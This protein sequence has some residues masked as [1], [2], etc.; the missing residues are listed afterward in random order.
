VD[1]HLIARH[2]AHDFKLDYLALGH[3]HSRQH[4][5][6]PDGLERTAYPGVHEPL[7]FP[8]SPESRTGWAPYTGGPREEFLDHGRGEV[9]HVR[10]D[11]PGA[12]P[13]LRAVEVGHLIWKDE[14]H[15]LSSAEELSRL[16]DHVAVQP[17]AERC[18]LRLQLEGILDAE[19]M[20]LLQQL[21]EVADRYLFAELDESGLHM[22]PTEAEIRAIAGEGVLRRVLEQLQEEARGREPP[23]RCIAERAL[24]LLY[25]IA[26]EAGT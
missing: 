20:M 5:R 10:I 7:R 14:R 12:P 24:M 9:L 23:Q 8:G 11:G 2:A 17:L 3:W 21:R 4:F 19:A 13:A 1:D 18:L 16:I 6:G 25:Q 15:E 22:Q 26:H